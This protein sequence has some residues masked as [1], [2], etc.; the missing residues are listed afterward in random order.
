VRRLRYYLRNP[1][2]L[3]WAT[4]NRL[5]GYRFGPVRRFRCCD[6]TTPYHYRWCSRTEN[7]EEP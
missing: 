6:H 4:R 7:V 5:M 1:R 3:G 2:Q